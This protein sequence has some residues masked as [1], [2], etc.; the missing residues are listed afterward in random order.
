MLLTYLTFFSSSFPPSWALSVQKANPVLTG[1]SGLARYL[2]FFFFLF[3]SVRLCVLLLRPSCVCKSSFFF[4]PLL[5]PESSTPL[6]AQFV[7]RTQ[8]ASLFSLAGKREEENGSLFPGTPFSSHLYINFFSR[9]F[10]AKN[11]AKRERNNVIRHE[12]DARLARLPWV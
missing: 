3:R 8:Q 10:W 12:I 11:V 4:L 6:T 9:S 1:G 2:T 7:L 5:S